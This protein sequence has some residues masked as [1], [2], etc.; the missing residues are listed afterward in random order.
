MKKTSTI[1]EI[2]GVQI[3][4]RTASRRLNSMGIKSRIAAVKDTLTDEHRRHRFNYAMLY[5]YHPVEFWRSVIFTDEKSWSSTSHGRSRDRRLKNE[6]F[7]RSNIME[8]RRS[9]RALFRVGEGC[10]MGVL[11]CFGGWLG[12]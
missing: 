3:S 7:N 6:R 11:S 4:A 5:R 8:I 9:G 1:A 10:G 2:A 12:I